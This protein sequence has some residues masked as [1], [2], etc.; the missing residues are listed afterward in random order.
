MVLGTATIDATSTDYPYDITSATTGNCR[1]INKGS[2]QTD[3]S[4]II[5]LNN[6]AID[7]WNETVIID[8]S[9]PVNAFA[10]AIKV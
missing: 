6:D 3:G 8:L 9:S 2:P 10:T 1:T 5:P 7:E 4:I